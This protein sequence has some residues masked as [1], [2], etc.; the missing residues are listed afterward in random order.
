MSTSQCVAHCYDKLTY[1]T[2]L[3]IALC[4]NFWNIN[5]IVYYTNIYAS[6]GFRN[7]RIQGYKIN[8]L[9]YKIVGSDYHIHLYI[10]LSINKTH[11]LLIKSGAATPQPRFQ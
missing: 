6:L 1:D 4:L 2:L 8:L 9:L 11:W 3:F 10:R 7:K 5:T